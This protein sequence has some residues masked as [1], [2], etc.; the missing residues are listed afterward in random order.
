MKRWL[1][2]SGLFLLIAGLILVIYSH[3]LLNYENQVFPFGNIPYVYRLFVDFSYFLAF[4]SPFVMIAGL[5]TDPDG[6][7]YS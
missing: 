7:V 1:L 5:E 4:V 6:M 2:F 3:A